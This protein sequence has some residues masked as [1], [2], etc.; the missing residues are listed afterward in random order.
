MR[1]STLA[2]THGTKASTSM[3]S[4]DPTPFAHLFLMRCRE[5]SLLSKHE[6]EDAPPYPFRSEVTI[7]GLRID[8]PWREL[9]F[10]NHRLVA[11]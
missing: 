11:A 4:P 3:A 8:G 1:F 7:P 2:C 9:I 10:D 6:F 5:L